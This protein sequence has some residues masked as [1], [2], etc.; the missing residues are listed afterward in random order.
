MTKSPTIETT[1]GQLV[2]ERPSR[3]R[4]FEKLGIDFCCGGN[5]TLS[6]ACTARGL[7]AE[8]VLTI[9]LAAEEGASSNEQ[10]WTTASLTAL[11]DHIEQTHHAYLKRELPRLR[12]MVR[13]VAAVH[14]EHHPWMREFDRVYDRF[15]TDLEAHLEE[16]EQVIF[17]LIRSLERGNSEPISNWGDGE[18]DPI[19]ALESEHDDAGDCLRQL[20]ELSNGFTPPPDACNTFSAMLDGVRELELD[21]HQHIHKE[22]NVLFPRTLELMR[23]HTGSPAD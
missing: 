19:R 21:L 16:E 23:Q 13:K 22:N 5:Q 11:A 14:G 2:A 9:L 17:P 18:Q 20:Q 4:V 8:T 1:V 15:A 10:N 12:G 6:Q 3:S 7:D